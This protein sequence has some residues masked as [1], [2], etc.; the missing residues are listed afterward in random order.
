LS[1]LDEDPTQQDRRGGSLFDRE[2]ENPVGELTAGSGDL[3]EFR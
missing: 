2:F 1:L 3:P